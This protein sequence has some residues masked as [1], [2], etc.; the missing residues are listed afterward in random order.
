MPFT[1]IKTCILHFESGQL[2]LEPNSMIHSAT[3][4][5]LTKSLQTF[6]TPF[7]LILFMDLLSCETFNY[8]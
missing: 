1:L 6:M 8:L 5:Q 2:F 4:H 3:C 7:S